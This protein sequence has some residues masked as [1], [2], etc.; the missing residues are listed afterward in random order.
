MNAISD[1]RNIA[2][3]RLLDDTHSTT[4]LVAVLSI[5]FPS[6]NFQREKAREAVEWL[7]ANGVRLIEL[8]KEALIPLAKG[9]GTWRRARS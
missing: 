3:I 2:D 8:P 5:C 6:M 7:R 4:A 1:T 9:S